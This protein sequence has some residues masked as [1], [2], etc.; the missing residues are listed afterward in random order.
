MSGQR[1]RR[2]R[3]ASAASTSRRALSH[4]ES[5]RWCERRR[6]AQASAS[7]AAPSLHHQ[8]TLQH[9]SRQKRASGRA[10]S[11]PLAPHHSLVCAGDRVRVLLSGS[12]A[13]HEPD[14]TQRAL[15]PLVAGGRQCVSASVELV[16]HRGRCGQGGDEPALAGRG[17]GRAPDYLRRPSGFTGD[18]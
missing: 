12:V 6:S 8:P 16:R 10:P 17:S 15:P 3:R 7:R 2:A 18:T 13:E 4:G 5:R 14:A 1:Q 11:S 9:D